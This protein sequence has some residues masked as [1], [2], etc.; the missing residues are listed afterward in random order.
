M[1]YEEAKTL[2]LKEFSIER[3]DET[4]E[5]PHDLPYGSGNFEDIILVDVPVELIDNYPTYSKLTDEYIDNKIIDNVWL[6]YGRNYK[7][8]SFI[9][10]WNFQF[11]VKDGNHR[12]EAAKQLGVKTVKAYMP[13]S[14]WR[15]YENNKDKK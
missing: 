12:I 13:I 1:K 15:S 8:G 9:P 14:H 7:D 3:E 2:Y 4:L 5:L 10:F 6:T 11:Q